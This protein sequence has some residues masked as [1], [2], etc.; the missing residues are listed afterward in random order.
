MT[1]SSGTIF[2]T[3][4]TA[5]KK[6]VDVKLPSLE[7]ASVPTPKAQVTLAS[8]EVTI[9]LVVSLFTGTIPVTKGFAA[10]PYTVSTL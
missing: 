3:A 5:P 7:M 4:G 8:Q 2:K 6:T 1:G 9:I 10:S